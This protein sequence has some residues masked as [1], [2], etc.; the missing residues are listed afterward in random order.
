MMIY[1]FFSV[2][3]GIIG[4]VVLQ[5]FVFD[6]WGSSF[7]YFSEEDEEG[8]QHARAAVQART[9]KRLEKILQAT[10]RAGR[11]TN[12]GVEELFCISDRTASVYLSQLTKSGR[13]Q[14]HGS[15]R[16][17]YYTKP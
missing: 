15:G 12:D 9:V 7:R 10:Q 1:I 8:L 2:C 14:R 16:G 6:R 11:I 13:L 5:R 3:A 17:T 4:G